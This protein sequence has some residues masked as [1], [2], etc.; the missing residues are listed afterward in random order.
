MC[1][2]AEYI[3]AIELTRRNIGLESHGQTPCEIFSLV[4]QSIGI[5]KPMFDMILDRVCRAIDQCQSIIQEKIE[6]SVE[7]MESKAARR[8]LEKASR[9]T[10]LICFDDKPNIATLCCGRAVHINCLAQWLSSNNTCPNCRGELPTLERQV[11]LTNNDNGG[12]DASD[13]NSTTSS[14]DPDETTTI[15]IEDADSTTDDTTGEIEDDTTS[16]V[17]DTPPQYEDTTTYDVPPSPNNVNDDTTSIVESTTDF[18]TTDETVSAQ[19]VQSHSA[20]Y[21]SFGTCNNRAAVDCMN[22]CC[23][24]CCVLYFDYCPRHSTY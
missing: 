17:D 20:I 10:C 1:Q 7:E 2:R 18:S 11:M 24:R 6:R 23:G 21:C 12:A 16:I 8:Y 5:F 13:T 19:P 9:G 15:Y 14:L 22:G 4:K 3:T